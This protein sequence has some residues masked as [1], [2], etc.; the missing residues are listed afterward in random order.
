MELRENVHLQHSYAV[1]GLII[2]HKEQILRGFSMNE[3]LKLTFTLFKIPFQINTKMP[4]FLKDQDFAET[5]G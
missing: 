2:F 3:T 5:K 1:E 4:S